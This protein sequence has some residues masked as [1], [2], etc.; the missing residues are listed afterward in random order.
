MTLIEYDDDDSCD[1]V[2]VAEVLTKTVE[3]SYFQFLIVQFQFSFLNFL[4]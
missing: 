4:L 1:S 3:F 2:V